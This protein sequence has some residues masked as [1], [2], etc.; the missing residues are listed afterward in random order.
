[1]S[2]HGAEHVTLTLTL[3][4][5]HKAKVACRPVRV[6]AKQIAQRRHVQ[7]SVVRL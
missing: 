3:V 2:E 4:P 6:K 7:K 1:M 5:L